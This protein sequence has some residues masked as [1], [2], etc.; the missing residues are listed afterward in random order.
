MTAILII[1][2]AIVLLLIGY[3]GYGSWLA[4]QWGI[5]PKKSTPAVEMEDGVDYVAAKPA[6]LMGHHFSSIAGAGP[7]NGPIRRGFWLGTGIFMVHHRW[8]FLRRPS[9][10]R[11]PVCI[12]SSQ[13]KKRR[14][15]HPR[16]HGK[17]STEALYHLC[18]AGADPGY[19]I[20]CQ[21]CCR[22]L[23]E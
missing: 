20:L 21:R 8:N 19:C 17:K 5:D 15:D 3:V 23:H 7:I 4:K 13:R 16:F 1:V 2:A 14:R 18:A 22:N 10:F 9:G 12:P 11:F 6:V